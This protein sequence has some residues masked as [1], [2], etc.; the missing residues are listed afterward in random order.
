MC[1][2]IGSLGELLYVL[3]VELFF[4]LIDSKRVEF[5]ILGFYH[6]RK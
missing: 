4:D 1:H 2:F 3:F 6:S 5:L